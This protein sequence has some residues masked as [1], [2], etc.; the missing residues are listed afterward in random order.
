MYF[1]VVKGKSNGQCLWSQQLR[2]ISLLADSPIMTHLTSEWDH[3]MVKCAGSEISVHSS[4]HRRV[5]LL[6]MLAVKRYIQGVA[7]FAPTQN[8]L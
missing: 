7:L 3:I 2:G 5:V 1:V 6:M 8:P 4:G